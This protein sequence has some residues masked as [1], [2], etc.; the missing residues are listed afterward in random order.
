MEKELY[1]QQQIKPYLLNLN[2]D[3]QLTNMM[4]HILKEGINY[5]GSI[6]SQCSIEPDI[7]LNGFE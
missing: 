5:I 6:N 7:I 2:K 3:P 1:D 4:V